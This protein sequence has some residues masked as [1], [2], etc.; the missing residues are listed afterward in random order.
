MSRS[1]FIPG[2]LHGIEASF[3]ADASL[4]KSASC[5]YWC[6]TCLMVR[7]VVIL[8]SVWFGTGFR[9]LRRY[10]AYRLRAA[11]AMALRLC[12]LSVLLRLGF[13]GNPVSLG[14]SGLDCP[15]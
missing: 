9:M 3:L 10:L 8:L 5:P 12:S 13:S 1:M 2:A 11:L 15:C 6:S 14:G 7:Q 4:R